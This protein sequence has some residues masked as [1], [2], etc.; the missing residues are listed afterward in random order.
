MV[1]KDIQNKESLIEELRKNINSLIEE[2]N[3]AKDEIYKLTIK[4]YQYEQQ[5][6][7]IKGDLLRRERE[8]PPQMTAIQ[9]N[10]MR[11]IESLS[12]KRREA[13]QD[14]PDRIVERPDK[15][16][17]VGNNRRREFARERAVTSKPEREERRPINEGR[18]EVAN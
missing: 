8:Q 1:K 9:D 10:F 12:P 18:Q 6:Q 14:H 5:N 16:E 4:S 15:G 11:S 17:P 2:N 13:R 3:I 7:I